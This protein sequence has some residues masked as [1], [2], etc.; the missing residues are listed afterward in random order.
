[1]TKNFFRVLV[2]LMFMLPLSFALSSCSDDDDEQGGGAGG[3]LST[4]YWFY[5]DHNYDIYLYFS[6]AKACAGEFYYEDGEYGEY[7]YEERSCEFEG[8]YTLSGSN[9]KI[10][11][12]K[13]TDS[14]ECPEFKAGTVL[15]GTINGEKLMMKIA[16]YDY[17]FERDLDS[18][19]DDWMDDEK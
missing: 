12:E 9:V 3:D 18:D 6:T 10:V 17:R 7:D 15:T 19:Y 8:E 11:I 5:E 14:R 13:C 1:M 2:T 4:G 16:G